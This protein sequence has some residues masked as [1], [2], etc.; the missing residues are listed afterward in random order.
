MVV[1]VVNLHYSIHRALGSEITEKLYTHPPE[2][3]C[4]QDVTMLWNQGV[5][6]GGDVN[7]HGPDKIIN[8]KEKNMHNDRWQYQWATMSCKRKQKIN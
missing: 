1:V 3:V 5:H 7:A 8:K 4:E 6:T 2:P